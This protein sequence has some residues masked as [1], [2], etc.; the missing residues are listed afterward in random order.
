MK[1]ISPQDQKLSDAD[2]AIYRRYVAPSTLGFTKAK[3][4]WRT[5]SKVGSINGLPRFSGL[6]FATDG[7]LVAIRRDNGKVVIGHLDSFVEVTEGK[8]KAKRMSKF[9]KLALEFS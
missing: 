7:V 5:I 1:T 9:D 8:P 6:A 2:Y 4:P 3:P